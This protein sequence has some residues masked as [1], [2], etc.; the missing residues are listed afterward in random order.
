[1]LHTSNSLRRWAGAIALTCYALGAWA[2][3]DAPANL[4]L[5]D[6]RAWL[7]ANWY[8]G[9]FDDLGYNGARSQMFSYANEQ[10]GLVHGIYTDFT[11]P[12]ENTTFLDPINAEHI[13]P[14]S[15][16]GG[17]SPMKSD[18]FNLH[19][20]HG[21]ANSARGNSMYGEVADATAQWYGITATGDYTTQG[22]IPF[23]VD[24]WSERSGSVWE[25]REAVK[26][27]LARMA[28]YFYTV[29]PTEAGS[30]EGLADPEVLYSWHL[31]DPVDAWEQLRNDRVEDVQGNR[32]FF[33]DHPEWVYN[34]WFYEG[35]L[36]AGCT[37]PF[38]CNYNDQANTN[39]GSCTYPAPG[40]DC[41]GN[42]TVDCTLFFS[43]CGEGSS[44]NK[45]LE[46]FNPLPEPV[47]LGAYG[48]AYVTND[49]TV[50]GEF[51]AWVDFPVGSSIAAGGVFIIAH[52]SADAAILAQADMTF[53]N[54][55]NGDDGFALMQGSPSEY[56]LIDAVGD[57]LGDPGSGW[58]VAGVAAAT[59]NHTLV[60]KSSVA[61]GNGGNWAASAGTDA[62]D[63]E[64]VVLDS[65]DWSDLAQ[66]T[67]SVACSG[68]T[69]PDE[70][71]NGLCDDQEVN[72]DPV[73]GCTYAAACNFS[74]LATIDDGSCNFTSC[75]EWGCTYAS[76]ENFN[77]LATHDD[78]S[79]T[80][81][82]GNSC[83]GDLNVDGLVATSDLLIMLSVFGEAC[84]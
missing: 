84:P 58:D 79:C 25:P 54:L 48:L 50:A 67:S 81:P 46:V 30:I 15:F 66:H 32:N 44:N 38:A 11:Q 57:F 60:R 53:G 1:M 26:G 63:S 52:S 31:A 42:P 5:G 43:E 82:L 8:V 20:A 23:N 16:F 64:W 75:T 22:S 41:A 40:M 62:S 21:S 65:D 49:P 28:F 72:D 33:V 2:Q 37:E 68:T 80:F 19:P 77:A 56:T 3:P 78:G 59:A 35:V 27:D 18:L 71:N 47:E 83:V 14:Q 34:A 4:Y 6:L 76:A 10:N 12:A 7:R 36:I 45:Y 73:P 17:V 39:D 69:C 55:S 13:I 29:Y 74:A 9:L 61:V 51:E 70:N 24:E